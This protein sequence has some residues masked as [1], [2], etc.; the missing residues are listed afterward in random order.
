MYAI[1]GFSL[2]IVPVGLPL[3][4]SYILINSYDEGR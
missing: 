2:V 1:I 4:T 3:I